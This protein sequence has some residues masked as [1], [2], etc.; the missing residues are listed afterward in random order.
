ML[1]LVVMFFSS[2]LFLRPGFCFY[3]YFASLCLF[4]VIFFYVFVL[5]WWLRL[6]VC[7]RWLTPRDLKKKP[8][9]GQ[10]LALFWIHWLQQQRESL[11][12]LW[13][14]KLWLRSL[15][16]SIFIQS[17]NNFSRK[18]Q[19]SLSEAAASAADMYVLCMSFRNI[20]L[21]FRAFFVIFFFTDSVKREV[22]IS[23]GKSSRTC[24]KLRKTITNLS[25]GNL[26]IWFHWFSSENESTEERD[27]GDNVMVK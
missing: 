1:Y 24:S 5:M 26:T 27:H 8:R 12:G 20:S 15:N 7:G 25:Q 9:N 21:A 18:N 11:L 13:E 2:N 6:C 4:V 19:G 22:Q 10:M 17:F 3:D 16:P 23:Q 14:E